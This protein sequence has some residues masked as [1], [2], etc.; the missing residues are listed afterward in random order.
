M[1]QSQTP[2]LIRDGRGTLGKRAPENRA[3]IRRSGRTTV[4]ARAL[5][6]RAL[7][8]L[9]AVFGPDHPDVGNCLVWISRVLN[10]SGDAEAAFTAARRAERIGRE[11]F[12]SPG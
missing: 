10:A 5:L 6:E 3:Q 9:E 1:A 2:F 7:R 4:E 11:H 12:A 8:D